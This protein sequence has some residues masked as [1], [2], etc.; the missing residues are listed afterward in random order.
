MDIALEATIKGID[1]KD[2]ARAND[3][4]LFSDRFHTS[5][6]EKN[7][8]EHVTEVLENLLETKGFS[9]TTFTAKEGKTTPSLG[10]RL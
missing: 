4:Y 5:A 8:P 3:D 2:P 10:P 7:T 9:K 1:F 6:S